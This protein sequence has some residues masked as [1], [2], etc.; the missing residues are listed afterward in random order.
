MIGQGAPAGGFGGTTRRY[1]G[2]DLLGNIAPAISHRDESGRATRLHTADDIVRGGGLPGGGRSGFADS[3]GMNR[4]S[5]EQV[6]DEINQR[7]NLL[8]EPTS[9]G[10]IKLTRARYSDRELATE[11][12]RKFPTARKALLARAGPT[13]EDIAEIK[14]RSKA[15][16][17][18]RMLADY[19]GAISERD[20]G[21]GQLLA[22][23]FYAAGGDPGQLRSARDELLS[24]PQPGIDQSALIEMARHL[25]SGDIDPTSTYW[26]SRALQMA[27][28]ENPHERGMAD[29]ILSRIGERRRV[30]EHAASPRGQMEVLTLQAAQEARAPLRLERDEMRERRADYAA[31]LDLREK[32]AALE[33]RHAVEQRAADANRRAEDHLAL[34]KQADARSKASSEEASRMRAARE[35]RLTRQGAVRTA[36]SAL[37]DWDEMSALAGPHDPRYGKEQSNRYAEAI[38]DSLPQPPAERARMRA[39]FAGLKRDGLSPIEAIRAIVLQWQS[40]DAEEGDGEEDIQGQEEFD[41]GQYLNEERPAQSEDF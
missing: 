39:Y 21:R 9:G 12:A 33:G 36:V 8:A 16:Q 14:A 5:M 28:S 3:S 27:G 24:R 4:V 19:S 11:A 15:S 1:I 7:R 35:E 18:N 41:F 22:E 10:G 38:L 23:R 26:T 37:R 31:E 6:I 30:D 2:R 17:M 32:E 29:A 34:S 20:V 25:S 13:Q 40:R